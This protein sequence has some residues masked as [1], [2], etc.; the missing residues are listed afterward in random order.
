MPWREVKGKKR[1]KNTYLIVSF[2]HDDELTVIDLFL[3]LS[4]FITISL[5]E[6]LSAEIEI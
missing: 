1:E 5:W 6:F 4:Y 3:C 2:Y